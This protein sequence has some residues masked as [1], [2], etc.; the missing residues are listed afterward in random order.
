[1]NPRAATGLWE[2]AAAGWAALRERIG[3]GGALASLPGWMAPLLALGGVLALALL[4]G[5]ALSALSTLIA[6]LL[7]A[8]LLLAHLF[9]V[10]IE[11]ALP[12]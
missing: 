4:A 9:G 3:F 12:R 11:L 1:M 5:I 2:Q 6:A 10:R 7:T 8:H